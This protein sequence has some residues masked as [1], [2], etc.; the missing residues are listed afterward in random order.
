[1][2]EMELLECMNKKTLTV[3]D[4]VF[5]MPCPITQ[6]VTDAQ[7]E[8]FKDAFA[9]TLTY[10]GKNLAV[11]NAPVF[12]ANRKEEISTRTFGCFSTK[13]PYTHNIMSQGEWLVSGESMDFLEKVMWNDEMD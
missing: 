10:K 3:D 7:K 5:L 13:H 4:K 11:I 12:F 8:E 1:M 2:N 9:I 6:H